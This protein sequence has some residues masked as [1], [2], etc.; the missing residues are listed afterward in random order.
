[1]YLLEAYGRVGVQHNSFI[2]LALRRVQPLGS[3]SGL[4]IRR[5]RAHGIRRKGGWADPIHGVRAL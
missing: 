2:I 4:I 5:K 3:R 1:L